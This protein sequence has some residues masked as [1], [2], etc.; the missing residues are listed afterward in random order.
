MSVDSGQSSTGSSTEEVFHCVI[1]K[2]TFATTRICVISENANNKDTNMSF[3][4]Q[5]NEQAAYVCTGK[6]Q[7]LERR[8][9]SIIFD[10]AQISLLHILDIVVII[11]YLM[12]IVMHWKIKQL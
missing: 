12:S 6:Q 1:L 7:C 10:N 4:E 3:V 5:L 11:D 2:C 8:R 9:F